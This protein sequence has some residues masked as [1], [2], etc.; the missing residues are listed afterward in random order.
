VVKINRPNERGKDRVWPKPPTEI[1]D[2]PWGLDDDVIVG[3]WMSPAEVR[4]E[5]A[6]LQ[7]A[8]FELSSKDEEEARR[9]KRKRFDERFR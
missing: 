8:G 9:F 2:E 7:E 3:S 6:K 1:E 5:M 4:R